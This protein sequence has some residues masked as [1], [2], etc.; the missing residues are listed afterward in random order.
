VIVA[1]VIGIQFLWMPI[2]DS[3][4]E[5]KPVWLADLADGSS[6]AYL[7]R[8]PAHHWGRLNIPADQP[9][10]TYI[11]A[12]FGGIVGQD[13]VGQL[14]DPF[15]D[16]PADYRYEDHP[17]EAGRLMA[18]WLKNTKT[19]IFVLPIGNHNYAAFLGDYSQLFREV[20]SVSDR[21]WLVEAVKSSDA[22]ASAC[23]GSYE[24]SQLIIN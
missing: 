19:S 22:V 18:C 17:A 7:Y 12:R 10:L 4:S 15:Y 23:V 14:Y 6:I 16:L 3:Y 11:L 5:T 1:S 8:E 9:T 13:L 21:G 20:G 2:Q 24:R